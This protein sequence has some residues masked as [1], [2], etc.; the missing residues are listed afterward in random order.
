[1]PNGAINKRKEQRNWSVHMAFWLQR[2]PAMLKQTKKRQHKAASLIARS[3]IRVRM[4]ND[5]KRELQ[6][7]CNAIAFCRTLHANGV[8]IKRK[9]VN[10]CA[11]I[12]SAKK[13]PNSVSFSLVFHCDYFQ[14]QDESS[15]E[16]WTFRNGKKPQIFHCS[17]NLNWNGMDQR[18][19]AQT[20][21]QKFSMREWEKRP[22]HTH[23]SYNL[24][25][26]F[27]CTNKIIY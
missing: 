10:N 25:T 19:I 9:T 18:E 2:A 5:K 23:H 4:G 6:I 8:K 22:L 12:L 13:L 11:N 1:M 14:V 16:S 21:N 27:N 15:T 24:F 20:E 3:A 7:Q 26:N 17:W